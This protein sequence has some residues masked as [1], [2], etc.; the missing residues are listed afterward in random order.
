MYKIENKTTDLA[1]GPKYNPNYE[2]TKETHGSH[3]VGKQVRNTFPVPVSPFKADLKQTYLDK[4]EIPEDYPK[5]M[6]VVDSVYMRPHE[7]FKA[8]RERNLKLAEKLEHF[9]KLELEIMEKYRNPHEQRKHILRLY[10]KYSKPKMLINDGS[11]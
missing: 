6:E 7:E 10:Q 1:P 5:M 11:V 9:S 2:K 4:R 3:A 8:E